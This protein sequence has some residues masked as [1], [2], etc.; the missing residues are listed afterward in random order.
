[1][2]KRVVEGTI[3]AAECC[4]GAELYDPSLPTALGQIGLCN[5]YLNA[6]AYGY[7]GSTNTAYGP[8][9]ANDQA[10]LLCR[11]FFEELLS[12]SSLGRACLQARLRYAT[13]KGG[14]LTPVDLK[15]LAQFTLM[16]DPSLTPVVSH[17]PD[18]SII[19]APGS[20]QPK[21]AR[22]EAARFARS[23]RRLALTMQAA[24][25]TAY[26]LVPR[27]VSPA[28][29]KT[30]S[31]GKLRK[32]AAELGIKAPDVLITYEIGPV[33]DVAGAKGFVANAAKAGAAPKA[34]HTLLERLDPPAKAPNL[35]LI[36]GVQGIEFQSGMSIQAFESR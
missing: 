24:A 25:T 27:T 15:T 12:G 3:M 5:T 19:T 6:K 2:T 35:R 11:Y 29:S 23:R 21:A 32:A 10:D 18:K 20:R 34:V 30:G 1:M 28:S 36:R 31:F 4:Y 7:F 17:P 16:A 13:A 8:T 9:A 26:R 14:V 22:F 33:L